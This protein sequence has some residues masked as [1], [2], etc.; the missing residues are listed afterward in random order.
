MKDFL[1]LKT[2]YRVIFREREIIEAEYKR[3]K[4]KEGFGKYGKI[5]KQMAKEL[6][7]SIGKLESKLYG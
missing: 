2:A 6:R 5:K 4:K 1:A 3:R 7:I